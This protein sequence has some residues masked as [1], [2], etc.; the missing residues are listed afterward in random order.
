[1]RP[2]KV[3]KIALKALDQRT[4]PLSV[5]TGTMNRLMVQAERLVSRRRTTVTIGSMMDRAGAKR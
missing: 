5:I 1:M 3:V 2:D 4:P